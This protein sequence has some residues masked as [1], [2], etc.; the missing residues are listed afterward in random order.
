MSIPRQLAYLV[1]TGRAL[2]EADPVYGWMDADQL[3]A[4]A[5]AWRDLARQLRGRNLAVEAVEASAA[6]DVVLEAEALFDRH[7]EDTP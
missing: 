5:D 6:P 4:Q 1:A 7:R 3:D 2:V